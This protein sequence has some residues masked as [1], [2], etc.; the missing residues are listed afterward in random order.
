[1]HD[2]PI[3]GSQ[4]NSGHHP[5]T[6]TVQDLLN[7]GKKQLSQE[8]TPYLDALV[9]LAYAWGC[10]KEHLYTLISDPVPGEIRE[11]YNGFITKRLEGYPVSYILNRKEFFSLTFYVDER[12]LVPRPDTEI[13]IETVADIITSGAIPV[14][15]EQS[16]DEFRILDICTGS[17][18]IPI[19][20]KHLYPRLT[21]HG[22][23]ISRDA[24]EVAEL[25]A[26]T[27]LGESIPLFH[28][29]LFREITGMYQIIT[30][31]PPYLLSTEWQEMEKRKW[32]EPQ[33]ALD[34][35]DDGLDLIRQIII[36]S[37]DK[38]AEFGYLLLEA[39]PDQADEI[40]D[41]MISAGF[42][43]TSIIQDL[44]G[45]NRITLGRIYA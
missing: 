19:T 16:G 33:I 6:I 45:R 22:A 27:I 8:E 21:I 39:A 38:L 31:N 3:D 44:A 12:V 34:G 41:L 40:Q 15:Q 17:G 11:R 1:M 42:S 20:L 24:L 18:C 32:P 43:D 30:A 25:N 5:E 36:D 9:L 37:I 14:G 28:S 2:R 4:Q 29:D 7:Q 23:D 13:M 10:R 26:R 35:G